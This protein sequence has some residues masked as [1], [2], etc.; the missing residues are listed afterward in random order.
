MRGRSL[1]EVQELLGH[2]SITMS[3]RY[4]HLA[5]EHL[6]QAVSVLEGFGISTTSTQGPIQPVETEVTTRQS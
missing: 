1:K 5:P 2:S 6:R 3:Q 4:A